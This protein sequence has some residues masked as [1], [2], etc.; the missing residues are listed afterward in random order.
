[1]E[2]FENIVGTIDGYQGREKDVI[3]INTVRA[4][5]S[6]QIGFLKD[7]RR[8]NVAMSRARE[9]LI[10]IGDQKT[11]KR[12]KDWK[13]VLQSAEIIQPKKFPEAQK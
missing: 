13:Q 9:L 11:L 10:I 8:M 5:A 7:K 3:I 4:N 1:M 12:D 6:G 2:G